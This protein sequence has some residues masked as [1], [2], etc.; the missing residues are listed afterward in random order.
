M[1]DQK[2]EW[3]T[4]CKAWY[5]SDR[6]HNRDP[7]D[8]TYL[9]PDGD[10]FNFIDET[11]T[12]HELNR[13]NNIVSQNIQ[14]SKN[15]INTTVPNSTNLIQ[16]IRLLVRTYWNKDNFP[17][18]SQRLSYNSSNRDISDMFH[19]IPEKDHNILFLHQIKRNP[20]GDSSSVWSELVDIDDRRH[21]MVDSTDF[22]VKHIF[23]TVKARV[24][25]LRLVTMVFQTCFEEIHKSTTVY[26]V[27][28][29][30][31]SLRINVLEMIRDMS[32]ELE[33][34]FVNLLHNELQLG[35]F[36]FEVN[37]H[38][39]HLSTE[40]TTRLNII[41][42]LLTVTIRNHMSMYKMHYIT[43]FQYTKEYQDIL[44]RDL[45]KR[46]TE[47]VK[48]LSSS[49]F[50]HDIVID[51]ITHEPHQE[52]DLIYSARKDVLPHDF[53]VVV[54]GN[55]KS[56]SD[57]KDPIGFISA[58]N[59]AK[60]YGVL[61]ET[62][63][64]LFP[65]H[66]PCSMYTS[67]NP[68]VS[69]QDPVHKLKKDVPR[70]SF[71]LNRIK[72]N[73]ILY[74]RKIDKKGNVHLLSDRVP[75]EILD[76]SH[77]NINDTKRNSMYVKYETNTLYHTARIRNIN[78]MEFVTLTPFGQLQEHIYMLFQQVHVPWHVKKYKKRIKRTVMILFLYIFS[79]NGPKQSFLRKL[80]MFDKM[81]HILSYD[82]MKNKYNIPI[83]ENKTI[84]SFVYAIADVQNRMGK[85]Q[86]DIYKQF[87][88]DIASILQ[89]FIELFQNEFNR[90]RNM[91]LT[92]NTYDLVTLM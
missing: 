53:A 64:H 72:F 37:S 13:T 26:L 63:Q 90:S 55:E 80:T 48:G 82:T 67:H 65:L 9:D 15:N 74:F 84:R 59:M 28:K 81:H 76:V 10:R 62:V 66:T 70:V 40:E 30:S 87:I 54:D 41:T 12:K 61:P 4:Y 16:Y 85:D 46:M 73:I 50:Y 31:V 29:G 18:L 39:A 49:N 42:Y 25:F 8:G 3:S 17:K 51:H 68:I 86:I 77:A 89:S 88:H 21:L 69:F 75:G 78:D 58:R 36:D 35:D 71:Q 19:N 32:S 14:Q 38:N 79:T 24:R 44:F 20:K 91:K 1:S 34:R 57:E 83:I 92:Y 56:S 22:T 2:E 5:K 23:G 11:C 43:F 7:Y 52:L 60:R 45:K 27:L 6:I 33:S 47:T